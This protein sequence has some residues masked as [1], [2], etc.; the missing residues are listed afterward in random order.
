[1]KI[2][3]AMSGG[4]DSSVTAAL[5]KQQGHEVIGITMR[6]FEPRITGAGSAVHDAAVVA[7]HLGIPH[8]VVNYEPGFRDL[9]INDFINEYCT[10]QTPN[11]CVRCNRYIKFGLLLDS[12]RDLGAELLATGHYV[13]KTSDPDGTCHL[14]TA[15]NIRKDQSYFLYTLSQERLAQLVFPLGEVES[16]DEVRRMARE[17]GLPVAEKSDSQEVCFIPNDDYIAFLEASGEVN[18]PPGEIIHVSGTVVGRHRG[19]HRYT[20]GQRKGLGISWSEPLFVVEIDVKRNAVIV[21]EAANV[22]ATGLIAEEISWINPPPADEFA[23]TCKIRYR[24]Q[25]VPCRAKILEG[26]RCEVVFD[27]PQKAVTPGQALVFYQG[28]AVLGGG[29]IVTKLTP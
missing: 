23:T 2:A 21:G 8:H 7:A 14:R 5:L 17:L 27:E 29:R 12:A 3:V 13:R 1:M 22:L 6:L 20:I 18:N 11:P 26:D 28:D 16:K 25:P 19:T 9:I 15:R 24:H 4:V 10:G